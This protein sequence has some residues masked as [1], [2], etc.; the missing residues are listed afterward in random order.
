VERSEKASKR[1]AATLRNIANLRN[2]LD[3][4]ACI[5][6]DE[7][8]YLSETEDLMAI[9]FPESE[10]IP[11]LLHNSLEDMFIWTSEIVGKVQLFQHYS[12]CVHSAD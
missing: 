5:V 6:E 3:G 8:A 7:T 11:G 10:G 9:A 2:W 4:S 1:E 12:T